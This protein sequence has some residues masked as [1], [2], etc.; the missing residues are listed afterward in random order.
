MAVIE[1]TYGPT[2]FF[3]KLTLFLLYL[4]I[5]SCNRATK[6]AI[7]LGIVVNFFFYVAT[8][9]YLGITCVRRSGTTWAATI[10]SAQ[11]QSTISMNYAQG[12]FS[13]ASDLYIFILPFP[14]ILKL[15]LP[16]RKKLGICAIFVAG[17]M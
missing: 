6:L 16:L 11:C 2:I 4:R 9:I 13:I 12:G 15:Q 17:T 5:F 14:T 8:T 1:I 3:A 7:Y 10:R